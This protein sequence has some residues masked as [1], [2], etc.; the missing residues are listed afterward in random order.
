MEAEILRVLKIVEDAGGMYRA[1]EA[2]LVQRMIGESARRFQAKVESGEQTVVGVNRYRAAEDAQERRA[3]ER[4]DPARMRAHIES[5]NTWK[6]GRSEA[7]VRRALDALASAAHDP[8][9]NVFAA[10]VAAA[11]AGCTHGEICGR[12]RRSLGFGHVQ[13]IL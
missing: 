4:P 3:L 1:V 8:K 6:A 12:L 13:A 7:V 10:V 11:E 5:F 9:A 2:G